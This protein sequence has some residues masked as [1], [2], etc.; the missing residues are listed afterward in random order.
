VL[1][2]TL[3]KWILKEETLE[4]SA[5][6]YMTPTNLTEVLEDSSDEIVIDGVDMAYLQ[7]EFKPQSIE[8]FLKT[9]ANSQRDTCDKLQKVEIFSNEFKAIIHT[10]KGVSGNL[11]I[12]KISELTINIEQSTNQEAVVKMVSQLCQEMKLTIASINRYFPPEE[13]ESISSSREETL[14]LIDNVLDILKSNSLIDETVLNTFIGTIRS[15]TSYDMS[16]QVLNAIDEF[17][18]KTAITLIESIKEAYFEQ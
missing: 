12:F 8:S 18:F 6:D 17:D 4:Q 13:A 3:I 9:F 7:K 14:E 16:Y 5:T 11:S 1:K 15:F 10:L 2:S